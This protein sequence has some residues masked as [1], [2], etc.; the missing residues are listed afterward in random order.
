MWKCASE[1]GLSSE[2]RGLEYLRSTPSCEQFS[3]TVAGHRRTAVLVDNQHAWID[4]VTL[5]RFTK[6][7][8]CK[9]AVF[10]SRDH[11]RTTYRL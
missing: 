3:E 9:R 5:D 4:R 2:T 8:L 6:H 7:L 1:K 11:P 10:V